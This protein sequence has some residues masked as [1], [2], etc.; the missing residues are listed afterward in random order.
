MMGGCSVL[1][2]KDVCDDA[3]SSEALVNQRQDGNE[4]VLHPHALAEVADGN[5]MFVFAGQ[6]IEQFASGW[7]QSSSV[8]LSRFEKTSGAQRIVCSESVLDKDVS[9]LGTYAHAG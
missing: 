7:P 1:N 5:V 4:L 8:R 3:S 2:A 6:S 9:E